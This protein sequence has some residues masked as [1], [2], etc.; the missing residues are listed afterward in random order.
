MEKFKYIFQVET[1]THFTAMIRIMTTFNRRRIPII[2][3]HS[4]IKE[5]ESRQRLM[6]TVL[7]TKD[8]ALKIVKRLEKE[9]DILT[10]NLFELASLN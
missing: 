2:E 9:V 3:M 8:N 1:E 6:I 10:V 4:N 5:G 7:E